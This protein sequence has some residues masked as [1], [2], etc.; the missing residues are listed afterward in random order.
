MEL[1]GFVWA[2]PGLAE[3]VAKQKGRDRLRLAALPPDEAQAL[4][5]SGVLP[6]AT[7]IRLP[8]QEMPA[9]GLSGTR[10]IE[11]PIART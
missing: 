2:E 9:L 1:P 5:G 8:A 11:T 4:V 3:R 10:I 7:K 6:S